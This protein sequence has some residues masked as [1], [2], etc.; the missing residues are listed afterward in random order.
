MCSPP[1]SCVQCKR[2]LE[3]RKFTHVFTWMLALG[4][5]ELL[6]RQPCSRGVLARQAQLAAAK[7]AEVREHEHEPASM[8]AMEHV[9]RTENLD[10]EGTL[11][12]GFADDS[13]FRRLIRLEPSARYGPYPRRIVA[14]EEQHPLRLDENTCDA[15]A[16]SRCAADPLRG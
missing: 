8:L 4:T 3:Q 16:M 13:C 14:L 10:P 2:A 15:D 9:Q 12:V 1:H 7:S 5:R 6:Q 11:L